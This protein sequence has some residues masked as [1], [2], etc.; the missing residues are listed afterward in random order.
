MYIQSEG[1][2]CKQVFRCIFYE[3]ELVKFSLKLV[4]FC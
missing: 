4:E 2:G 3:Q 1:E